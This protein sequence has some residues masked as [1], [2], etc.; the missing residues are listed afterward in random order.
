MRWKR[1]GKGWREAE[2]ID[3]VTAAM[4]EVA[5][6]QGCAFWRTR[7][8]MGGKGSIEKWRKQKLANADHVHLNTPGYQRLAGSLI[9]ELLRAYDGWSPPP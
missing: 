8:V 2:S 5:L 9:E 6:E 4:E 1:D 3:E 7:E